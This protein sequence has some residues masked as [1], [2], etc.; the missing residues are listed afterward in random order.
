MMNLPLEFRKKKKSLS[1]PITNG[2]EINLISAAV[3]KQKILGTKKAQN[4][5]LSENYKE[6]FNEDLRCV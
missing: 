3:K 6:P 4:G 1:S 2:H 5:K